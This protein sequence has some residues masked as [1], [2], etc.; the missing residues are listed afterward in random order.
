[1]SRAVAR[2]YARAL[3]DLLYQARLS[4]AER[5]GE[6]QAVKQ[7]LTE[8][9]SLVAEHSQL[10]NVLTNP[11][12]GQEEKRALLDRLGERLGWSRLTRNFLG[13]MVEN[14]RLDL[15]GPVREA[16]DREVYGRLGIVPVEVQTAAELSPGERQGLAERLA[17]LTGSEVELRVA[18]D[19]GILAGAVA[20][21][22]SVVYDGSLRAQ[23]RRLQ[24]ELIQGGRG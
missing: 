9:A 23:L 22:G 8:F 4:P 10:R 16:F 2:R 24:Q 7:Q 5:R 19:P 21:I 20:R 13:V 11:A 17:A 12:L 3:A 6:V 1:M 18:A 15:L 14:R